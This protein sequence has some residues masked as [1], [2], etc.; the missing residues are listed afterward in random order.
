MN[1]TT[2]FG[3]IL[4][5]LVVAA[6]FGFFAFALIRARAR[7]N[8]E[9][10]SSDP[11]PR[12][13][14]ERQKPI[15]QPVQPLVKPTVVPQPAKPVLVVEDRPEPPA[16]KKKA[17][18]EALTRG[19]SRTKEGL[20]SRLGGLF[21]TSKEIPADLIARVEEV[22]LTSDIGVKTTALLLDNLKARLSKNELS[23][24]TKLF[25]ALEEEIG[26][27]LGA[28]TREPWRLKPQRPCVFLMVGVNG[29]GKTTTIG[30]L[31]GKFTTDGLKV[32]VAAGDTFRAAAADQLKIWS[33]RTGAEYYSGK[34]NQDPASVV[35]EACEAG[36]KSGVD[37]IL[38]DTAGRLHTKVNLM[39]E[40]KKVKR[41]IG[42][43]FPDAPHEIFLVVDGTTGQN[44][45]AQAREFHDA[46]GLTGLVLTKLD[47]TAKGGVVV[48]IESDL[49]LPIRFIGVGESVDD[50][51]VFSPDDFAAAL[52][53]KAA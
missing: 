38:C 6:F 51:R 17:P 9:L 32:L 52:F 28:R 41:V 26:G 27:L 39:D 4:A 15:D 36:K 53:A 29:V 12:L 30:K 11:R 34:P 45:V 33:E 22:L 44:A 5:A 24:E 47:G 49:G 37:V 50:L 18:D 14:A 3:P 10:G 35:F 19:L 21:G 16:K 1:E 43:V 2:S 23:D 48:A 40:L 8:A 7:R 20:F 46:L 42:K 25:D 13:Q 31:A